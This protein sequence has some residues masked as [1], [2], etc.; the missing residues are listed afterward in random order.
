VCQ[1]D[2]PRLQEFEAQ[3][4]VVVWIDFDKHPDLVKRH[5]VTAVPD[6]LVY[7]GAQ[8]RVRTHNLDEAMQAAR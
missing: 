7:E 3:G 6:Y 8:L 4:H 1:R 5:N 2:K